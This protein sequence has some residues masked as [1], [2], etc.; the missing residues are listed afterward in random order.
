MLQ[1]GFPPQGWDLAAP[2]AAIALS[3]AQPAPMLPWETDANGKP[4]EGMRA[5]AHLPGTPGA[6]WPTVLSSTP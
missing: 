3:V 2:F 5:K 1:S 6:V 4:L